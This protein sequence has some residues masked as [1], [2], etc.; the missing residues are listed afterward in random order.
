MKHIGNFVKK[1]DFNDKLKHV[2]RKITSDKTKHVGVE[3]KLKEL[4]E[5]VKLLSTNRGE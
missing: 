4:S 1:T 5:R 3:K 2:N